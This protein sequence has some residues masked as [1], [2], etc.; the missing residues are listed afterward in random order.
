MEF[1]V[2]MLKMRTHGTHGKIYGI[3]RGT[4]INLEYYDSEVSEIPHF[5]K[6]Y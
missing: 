6:C 5:L 2:R 1:L 4:N 3:P